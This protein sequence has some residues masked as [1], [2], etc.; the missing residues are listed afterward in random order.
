[1]F[2]PPHAALPVLAGRSLGT[3]GLPRNRPPWS[4]RAAL[5]ALPAL[6]GCAGTGPGGF[7]RSGGEA[8]IPRLAALGSHDPIPG[9]PDAVL[10]WTSLPRG[11]SDLRVVL[12][13]HGFAGP[14]GLRLASRLHGS[15]LVLPPTPPTIAIMLRG[16]PFRRPGAFDWP[17]LAAPGGIEAVVMEVLAAFGPGLPPVTRLVLTAHSGG[18]GGL[19]GALAAGGGVRIDEAFFFDA[20]YGDPSP[21]LRWITARTAAE[22]RGA[23]PGALIA[24]AARTNEGAARRLAAG[25]ARAGLTGPTRRVVITGAAHN[26]IPSLYG[27]ALLA[28]AAAVLPGTA[29][30]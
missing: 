9:E 29:L 21:T 28:N 26:D 24:I 6:A 1:L 25:L 18:G 2:P 8:V 20:L 22:S 10:R 16:R 13:F 15:G 17:A 30:A 3:T 27:P 19:Q 14:E 7:S 5:L 23:P 11:A 4:R 12:H